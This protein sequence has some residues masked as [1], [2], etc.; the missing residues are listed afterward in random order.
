VD[1]ITTG[2]AK[3]DLIL[4]G[5]LPANSLYVIAGAAGTGKTILAQQFVF[6]NA[7]SERPA[8]YLTTLSEPG[9]KLLRY[10]QEYT[11]F[12]DE[13][14][15]GEPAPVYY[16]DVAVELKTR[17]FA[18]LPEI[19]GAIIQEH[20]PAFLVIDSFKALRDLGIDSASLRQVLFDLAGTLSAY[21]CTT[22]L[23]GEYSMADVETLPE[24]A[25]AD[26]IIQLV[27]QKHGV[28]DERYLRVI[29]L[30]GSGFRSGEHAFRITEKGLSIFPR[31]VTPAQP[32]GH[33]RSD[34]RISTGV[35][36][37][38]PAIGG[39]LL[40]GSTSLLVGP[41]GSGKTILGLHFLFEGISRNEPGLLASFEESPTM[42]GLSIASLGFDSARL[43]EG[44]LLTHLYVS[45]VEMNIDDVM[46]RIVTLV[47]ARGIRRLVVDSVADLQATASD[48]SRFHSYIYAMMQYFAAA[49]ITTYFTLEG[50]LRTGDQRLSQAQVSYLCDNV[51]ALDYGETEG[52]VRRSLSV[53]KTRA[54]YHDMRVHEFT[55][56]D[57][58]IE[59]QRGHT[60][61]DK[62]EARA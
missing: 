44:G 3:L 40:R 25:I 35:L 39:G 7:T 16:H 21:A 10:L 43:A 54:S 51:I 2:N 58:G 26:G 18:A 55:I 31:L 41:T 13:K 1:R 9:P 32:D 59:L 61:R 49:N 34:E 28:R 15:Y 50:H 12:D 57:R 45:A 29:K 11:F 5:G 36:K 4:D 27:N 14:L 60:S 38:D 48:E 46:E 62:S 30:R 22:L 20:S 53:V 23:V 6:A 37:L 42:V 52:E 17:G 19:I 47:E 56:G 8:V 24:F 33:Q